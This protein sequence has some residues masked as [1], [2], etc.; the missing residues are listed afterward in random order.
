MTGKRQRESDDDFNDP[1]GSGQSRA[2]AEHGD[3][4]SAQTKG[5]T[6]RDNR[7]NRRREQNSRSEGK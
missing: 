3:S 5:T 6:N 2:V 7:D 1:A 4:E